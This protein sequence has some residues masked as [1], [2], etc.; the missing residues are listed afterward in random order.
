MLIYYDYLKKNDEKDVTYKVPQDTE[1]MLEE[2][3]SYIVR[4]FPKKEIV[5]F[6]MNYLEQS[7]RNIAVSEVDY[8]H[9]TTDFYYKS[10]SQ[11]E[12]YDYVL[13]Q[14][15]YIALPSD[16]LGLASCLCILNDKEYVSWEPNK[17]GTMAKKLGIIT[18]DKRVVDRAYTYVYFYC[19]QYYTLP[20]F[21]NQRYVVWDVT[22]IKK[23]GLEKSLVC[24]TNI[25]WFSTRKWDN[26]RCDKHMVIDSFFPVDN[27]A[28]QLLNKYGFKE[29]F[30]PLTAQYV[31]ATSM[32]GLE[33]ALHHG[34]YTEQY[35]KEYYNKIKE[36][37]EYCEKNHK[38]SQYEQNECDKISRIWR[39][40]QSPIETIINVVKEKTLLF[41]ERTFPFRVKA[42]RLKDMRYKN[43]GFFRDYGPGMYFSENVM[44]RGSDKIGHYVVSEYDYVGGKFVV[45][46]V[47]PEIIKYIK[48]KSE[49]I[50]MFDKTVVK[51]YLLSTY[52]SQ[53]Y[54]KYYALYVDEREA[55]PQIPTITVT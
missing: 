48:L 5:K 26:A 33:I 18:D 46:H 54:Q 28:K 1:R 45:P 41:T 42:S 10:M 37:V 49:H 24:S 8:M 22:H 4:T 52:F 21:I 11:M 39:K 31:V 30:S 32:V 53:K 16:G 43:E 23:P 7:A 9:F 51:V 2:Y 44:V 55:R 6:Y 12:Q 17:I 14:F 38:H 50:Q 20:E 35:W 15:E 34:L 36:K 19:V 29:K 13:S 3:Y 40:L 25:R 27:M 47:R